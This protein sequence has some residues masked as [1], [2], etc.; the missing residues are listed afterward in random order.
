MRFLFYLGHPAHYLNVAVAADALAARGHQVLFV[1]REK[2]V[3][4]ELLA[5]AR[6]PVVRVPRRRGEGRLALVAEVV[7]R[8]VLMARLVHRWKPD[9]LVGT[10][11]VITHVGRL[12]GVPSVVINEDDAAAVP[13]FARYGL[14]FASAIL[15]PHCCDST[16]Y[17][18]KKVGYAGYHELAYLHPAHF[19]P[20][21]ARAEALFDGH[22]RYF[23]LRFSA[24]T[25]HHDAGMRGITNALARDLID[26]LAPRGRVHITSERSLGAAL[27]PYRIRIDPR[28]IHHALAF[29]DLYVG[30]SQTMTA[31]AAVLGTPAVRFNDFVGRLSYLEELEHVFGLTRGV[32]ADAPGALLR[33]VET[34]VE[35]P[36]LKAQWQARRA[37][38]LDATI[39]V[40]AFFV[41][42]LEG[43][44]HVAAPAPRRAAPVHAAALGKAS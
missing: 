9:L 1:A 36:G 12:L 17:E 18:H 14:R 8:E 10:D 32:P 19:T 3:L 29:A 28:D 33:V 5:D 34:L 11:I 43:Y 24:L 44:P 42:Y 31:E 40:A 37:H 39:D 4:F 15:A 16:P 38:L 2:D 22:D 21:R 20:D 23:I 7:R 25:A 41:A 6:H 35:T 26:V 13:L 27:E 30:D